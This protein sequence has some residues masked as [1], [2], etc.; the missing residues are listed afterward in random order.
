MMWYQA[1]LIETGAK[2]ITQLYTKLVAEASSGSGPLPGSDAQTDFPRT[3]FSSLQELVSFLRTMPLP[4]THP[5]H[6]AAQAIF[7]TLREAQRGYADMRGTWCRK[8]L[9]GQGKRVIDR[10]DSIDAVL[11]G[12]EFG[13]WVANLLSVAE[14]R[15]NRLS[16]IYAHSHTN[17]RSITF[18]SNWLLFLVPQISHRPSTPF[19][20][21]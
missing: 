6:P 5:S 10:V 12:K 7:S 14:V 17:R 19:S 16:C 18:S 9:E 8:C 15:L 11:A 13:K 20:Y 3:L 1:R 21:R 2:K 4:A